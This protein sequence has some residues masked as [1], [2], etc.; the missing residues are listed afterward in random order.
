MT[1]SKE[2]RARAKRIKLLLMDIDGVLTD[3]RIYYL[4]APR[5]GFVET[6]GFNSRDG[7]GIRLAHQAGLKTG[8]ISGRGGPIVEYR[9]KELGIHYVVLHHLEK[10]EAYRQ[11]LRTAEVAE[12]DVCYMGDDLV[13]L[14]ILKRSGLA[15]SVSDGHPL[16][17]KHVHH[18]TRTGGGAGAVREVI[19]LILTA[20]GKFA[21]VIKHY[22]R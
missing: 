10:L 14:P 17:R 21:A 19:E 11:M 16:L 2:L 8:V 9:L 15:V 18:V 4:P 3:G 22:L 1:Q 7:L 5:G 20:Q 13:D 12:E 6:K